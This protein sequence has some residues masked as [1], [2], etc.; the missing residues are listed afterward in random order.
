[1]T[2]VVA[3]LAA[4]CFAAAVVVQQRAAQ[5]HGA[6]L[7]LVVTPLWL[8]GGAI[9]AVGFAL[10]VIALHLGSVIEVQVLQVAVLP[11]GLLIGRVRPS[12]SAWLGVAAVG[13][14]LAGV[15]L[16]ANPRH[17]PGQGGL[18]PAVIVVSLLC[19]LLL[20]L[21]RGSQVRSAVGCALAAGLLFATTATTAHAA[22]NDF[23]EH[24]LVGLLARPS[25]YLTAAV[26]GAGLALAQ[27]AYANGPLALNLVV[28]TLLDPL[29]SLGLGVVVAGDRL[30]SGWYAVGAVAAAAVAAGGVVLLARER[31]RVLGAPTDPADRPG[32][33]AGELA[34]PAV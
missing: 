7:S 27:R 28:L 15:I 26:S 12:R 30:R 23:G 32:S 14:G 1:M 25:V 2:V 33:A 21:T 6:R 31:S 18:I 9:D 4:A 10:Q 22:G 11:F 17:G 34:R 13:V 24:G 5:A 20:V 8:V 3:L 19:V 29:A 16:A